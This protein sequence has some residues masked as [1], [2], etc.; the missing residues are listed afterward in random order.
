MKDNT[1]ISQILSMACL[2]AICIGITS[3]SGLQSKYY[4]G[5]KLP[6]SE[7][8]L[9]QESIWLYGDDT[10]Y[11]RRTGSNTFVIARMMWNEDKGDYTV[12]SE[13]IVGSK[14]GDHLFLNIKGLD[15][16]TIFRVG[17][18]LD[19]ALVLYSADKDKIAQDITEGKVKAHKDEHNNI[20]LD[21][22]KEEQDAYILKNIHSVFATDDP[23]IARLIS[24]K[25]S[26]NEKVSRKLSGE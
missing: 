12:Q 14:L 11:V 5:E 1:M 21:G 3:C 26:A 25:K 7:D 13:P 24:E 20:I 2:L 9:A 16:Y 17:F 10:Y 15:Y 18:T 22:T 6:I 23:G 4:V 8:D 19:D